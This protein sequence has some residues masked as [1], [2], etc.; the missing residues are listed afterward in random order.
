MRKLLILIIVISIICCKQEKKGAISLKKDESTIVKEIPNEVAITVNDTI[1]SQFHNLSFNEFQG[2]PDMFYMGEKHN[3]TTITLPVEEQLTIKGGDPFRGKFSYNNTF[4]KGDSIYITYNYIN[5]NNERHF[6]YPTFE[7]TN[8]KS[9]FCEINFD[10]LLYKKNVETKALIP[11][12]RGRWKTVALDFKK[13]NENAK[14]LLD[15]L[16][17]MNAISTNFKTT[18]AL[19]IHIKGARAKLVKAQNEKQKI[20]ITDLGI[21]LNND[22]LYLNDTYL[23]YLFMVAKYKYFNGR[24]KHPKSSEFYDYISKN[25]TFL[26]GKLRVAMLKKSL[27]GINSSE[28]SKFD[29]YLNKFKD[30]AVEKEDLD[31]IERALTYQ[32]A[33]KVI[34]EYDAGS[35]KRMGNENFFEFKKLLES[36]KGKVVLV[37]FWAS[38]CSPC[39]KETPYLKKL[40]KSIDNSKFTI[41]SIS[42]DKDLNAWER[43]SKM[44]G[45]D[46]NEHNYLISHWK[47][48]F[49]F[50]NY[51]IKTIPRYL[52]FDKNGKIIDDDAPRPSSKELKKLIEENMNTASI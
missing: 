42:T 20:N 25:E 36:E 26:K 6:I 18:K 9:N 1:Y 41:I 50:N 19:D 21:S 16:N 30:V 40:E 33:Q 13:N 3:R 47:K 49:L 31:F 35:L 17:N 44:D 12:V 11:D 27:K 45:L 10:Y 5:I 8:R 32:K 38:W 24:K 51:K 22:E 7:I 48:S 34:T 2:M 14:F 4:Q 29:T 37:D 23:S 43:A 46:E 15:S 28:K 52:L 39:R